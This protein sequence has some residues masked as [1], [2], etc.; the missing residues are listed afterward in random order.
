MAKSE[1]TEQ[2]QKELAEARTKY[3][4]AAPL[5]V[6]GE[7]VIVRAASLPELERYKQ[8]ANASFIPKK[9][10]GVTATV[11]GAEKALALSCIV[12]PGRDRVLELAELQGKLY[13]IAAA[14]AEALAESEIEDLEGN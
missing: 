10:G 9:G 4:S 1:L 5:R 12:R 11:A 13:E 6:K 14:K 2:E 7:L 8:T 3:G